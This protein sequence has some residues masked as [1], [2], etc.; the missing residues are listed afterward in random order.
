MRDA[1]DR[2]PRSQGAKCAPSNRG[3]GEQKRKKQVSGQMGGMETGPIESIIE[4]VR[5]HPE[6]G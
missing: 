4:N 1:K 5:L 3:D 2:D 6:V